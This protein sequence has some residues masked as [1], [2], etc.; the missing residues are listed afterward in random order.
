[1]Q[2]EAFAR[3]R[4]TH[5]VSLNP[6]TV[7]LATNV[8]RLNNI[9]DPDLT[10]VGTQPMGFDQYANFYAHYEVQAVNMRLTFAGTTTGGTTASLC[11]Y[12][13]QRSSGA[14]SNREEAMQASDSEYRV[15]NSAGSPEPITLRKYANIRKSLGI[16]PGQETRDLSAE[17]TAGPLETLYM[18]VWTGN[19]DPD[20]TQDPQEIHCIVDISFLVR[21]HERKSLAES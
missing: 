13:L 14:P 19:A 2:N 4:W 11:G 21:F 20:G 16:Q 9:Y 6:T 17:V 15:L 10:G 8:Y 1:M 7:A 18:S 12:R 3:L 5:M